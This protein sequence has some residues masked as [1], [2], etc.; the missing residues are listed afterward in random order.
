MSPN[1]TPWACISTYSKPC[2]YV[3][4]SGWHHAPSVSLFEEH[5]RTA[6]F[7]YPGTGLKAL[8]E[9]KEFCPAGNR[10]HVASV[11]SLAT[12]LF[13]QCTNEIP[14]QILQ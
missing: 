7:M 1:L 9:K 14:R 5:L 11:R 6:Y 4:V 13:Q 8:G 12:N 2:L 3:V 10:T